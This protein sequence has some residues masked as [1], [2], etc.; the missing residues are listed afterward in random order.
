M[1]A[2]LAIECPNADTRRHT[3][4]RTVAIIAAAVTIALLMEGA[5]HLGHAVTPSVGSP[6]SA[7]TSR[8]TQAPVVGNFTGTY[9]HDLPIYRLP[10]VEIT[11][12]RP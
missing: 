6:A 8:A 11:A 1:S 12:A 9:D 3:S 4:G 7:V 5:Q 2:Q 10:P